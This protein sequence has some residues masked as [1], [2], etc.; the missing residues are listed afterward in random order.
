MLQKR[1][2]KSVL[3]SL[4]SSSL[5]WWRAV[6]C[7]RNKLTQTHSF[8]IQATIF[9]FRTFLRFCRNDLTQAHSFP[10][11]ARIFCFRTEILSCRNE[12]TQAHSFHF[13]AVN[14]SSRTEMWFCTTYTPENRAGKQSHLPMKVEPKE[15]VLCHLRALQSTGSIHDSSFKEILQRLVQL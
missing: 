3:L 10:F 4:Q 7:C 2:D 6:W 12:G 1:K 11:Q 15:C 8:R 5:Y 9:C 13:Q 14:S